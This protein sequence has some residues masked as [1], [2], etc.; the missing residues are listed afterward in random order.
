MISVWEELGPRP[1]FF[2]PASPLSLAE[3]ED[4]AAAAGAAAA[5]AAA[6]QQAAAEHEAQY[7]IQQQEQGE[8][9]QAGRRGIG[10]QQ[11]N[12]RRP[13]S[14]KLVGM[15]RIVAA[16]VGITALFYSVV[17]RSRLQ[18]ARA[19]MSTGVLPGRWN[20]LRV[21]QCLAGAREL[22]GG[23]RVQRLTRLCCPCPHHQP[24]VC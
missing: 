7:P 23:Q 2:R 21:L 19:S 9:R 18:G 22:L 10:S 6:E 8:E 16:A 20:A 5:A 24:C 3:Q 17:G 15:A 14:E 13:K 12:G 4:A 1:S 11:P